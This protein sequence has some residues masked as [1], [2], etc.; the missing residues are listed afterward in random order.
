MSRSPDPAFAADEPETQSLKDPL[1]LSVNWLH[2]TEPAWSKNRPT[3][4]G[5]C[6]RRSAVA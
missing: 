1:K 2:W 4:G 6:S 5:A 3:V